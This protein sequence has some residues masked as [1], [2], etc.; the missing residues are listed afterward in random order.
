MVAKQKAIKRSANLLVKTW[1][2]NLKASS[3]PPETT[4]KQLILVE[5]PH[6]I[7]I[8]LIEWPTGGP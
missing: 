2:K 8:K 7:N 6:F 4:T 1:L 5:Y 3:I